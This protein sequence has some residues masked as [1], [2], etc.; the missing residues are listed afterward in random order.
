VAE[1]DVTFGYDSAMSI[2][3]E[4]IDR[5]HTTASSHPAHHSL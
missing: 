3:T 4:A 5:L 2:A 1:T